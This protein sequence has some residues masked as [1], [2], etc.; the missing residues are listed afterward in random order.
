MV[1]MIKKRITFR[2]IF[3]YF[4][5]GLLIILPVAG[6]AYILISAFS[7]VDGLIDTSPVFGKSI[8]GLGLLV[9]LGLVTLVGFIGGGI[10]TKPLLDFMDHL[11]EKIPGIKIIYSSLKDFMEA[12]VGEKKKFTEPVVV[13]MNNGLFKMGF[14]TSRELAK[15]SLEGYVA[16][17]FPHSYNFSGNVFLVPEE[18]IKA[19]RAN[20]SD[21]MKFIVSGGVMGIHHAETKKES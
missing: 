18:K 13:E 16:V 14:V 21:F 10:L 17:Y 19:V 20:S 1:F 4:L 12:F 11:L 3:N 8:P 2:R 15:I 5:G 7:F 6:T 9:V